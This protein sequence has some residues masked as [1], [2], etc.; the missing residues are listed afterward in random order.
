MY[1]S[2]FLASFAPPPP[3]PLPA[4]LPPPPLPP[5]LAFPP[6][7]VVPLA[8]GWS[9]AAASV[10]FLEGAAEGGTEGV[11]EVR[12]EAEE[13]DFLD[14]NPVLREGAEPTLVVPRLFLFS[15]LGTSNEEDGGFGTISTEA[16]LLTMLGA[17]S[18]S[19]PS[20]F[21]RKI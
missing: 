12:I 13:A 11:E 20:E 5:P 9:F 21:A 19:P 2:S 3:P 1:S 17:A 15:D 4:P 10:L 7:A 14:Q 6:L 18:F 8:L 16:L